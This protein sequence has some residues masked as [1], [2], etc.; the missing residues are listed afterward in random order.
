MKRL[1]ILFIVPLLVFTMIPFQVKADD[2]RTIQDE[3]IYDLLVDRYNNG[4]QASSDQ[5]D[6]HDP[7][8]YNG[9]D[10]DGITKMIEEIVLLNHIFLIEYKDLPFDS[11]S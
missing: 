11:V 7:Y 8:T 2:K 5:V 3:I 4:R 9:G 1:F 10:I 6:I